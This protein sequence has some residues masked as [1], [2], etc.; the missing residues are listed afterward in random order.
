MSVCLKGYP[1]YEFSFNEEEGKLLVMNVKRG[2]E[3]KQCVSGGYLRVNLRRDGKRKHFSV[4]RLIM[5]L[6]GPPQPS[7]EQ[8]QIVHINRILHD[9]RL[10]NL[11]WASSWAD[12]DLRYSWQRILE[13]IV[14][15]KK[16]EGSSP[17]LRALPT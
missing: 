16:N 13:E 7:P 11:R 15:H 2:R 10:S 4:A 5:I 3:V 9:N 6:F 17:T 14:G 1:L 8:N 12:N